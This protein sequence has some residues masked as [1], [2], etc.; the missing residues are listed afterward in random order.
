VKLTAQWFSGN[1]CSSA[2]GVVTDV[3]SE[4]VGE[5]VGEVGPWA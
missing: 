2:G 1:R 3:L 4:Q 5:R